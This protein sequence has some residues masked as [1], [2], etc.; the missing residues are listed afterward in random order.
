M[1]T[2]ISLLYDNVCLRGALGV[3]MCGSQ[4]GKQLI[5]TWTT[6]LPAFRDAEFQN[7]PRSPTN[8]LPVCMLIKD[9]CK[10]MEANMTVL[11]AF[12]AFLLLTGTLKAFK[13]PICGLVSVPSL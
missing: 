10:A 12:L 6:L 13:S 11:V 3:L 8:I 2:V 7:F 5:F 9:N 4:T 1:K